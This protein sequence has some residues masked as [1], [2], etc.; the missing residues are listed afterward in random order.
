MISR[1]FVLLIV[2]CV[3]LIGHTKEAAPMAQDPVLEARVMA[4]SAELRC[5]VCQN[6]T[7][8]DSH[9]E[10]AI[11]LKNQVREMLIAG[12]SER[13]I[14]DYMVE[15]YGE[16]ILYKPEVND[17]TFLL[18]FGPLVLFGIGLAVLGYNLKKRKRLIAD[19]D[20]TED[21]QKRVDDILKR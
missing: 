15:R 2:F 21:E 5:L 13:E 11:D 4:I 14:K 20:I 3:P 10:L 8:A 17:T 1:L 18:W 6:Q 7:I 9:A 12:K 19:V 16:F